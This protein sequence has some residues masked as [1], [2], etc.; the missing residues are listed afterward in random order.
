MITS[1]YFLERINSASD[2][3]DVINTSLI[4]VDDFKELE[5]YAQHF[6][7]EAFIH[8]YEFHKDEWSLELVTRLVALYDAVL[9]KFKKIRRE[10]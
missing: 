4:T 1:Q 9:L 3:K 2:V 10:L 5:R 8:Y 7:N 6:V